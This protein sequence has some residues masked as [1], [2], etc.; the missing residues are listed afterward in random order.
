MPTTITAFYSF[1][2]NTK[3]KSS[4]VNTNFNNFRGNIIP[5]NDDTQTAS[6]NTHD[7]GSTEHR[8][9]NAYGV[10]YYYAGE[11][12]TTYSEGNSTGGINFIIDGATSGVF[13]KYSGV[14]NTVSRS[15]GISQVSLNVGLTSN[16]V[17]AVEVS[18][19]VMT[20]NTGGIPYLFEAFAY[21][22]DTVAS[23][24]FTSPAVQANFYW[25]RDGATF[26]T[27]QLINQTNS[28]LPVSS[29]NTIDL[30]STGTHTY[31]FFMA[32]TPTLGTLSIR[33]AH[34]IARPLY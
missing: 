32:V 13:A 1:T 23:I 4:E 15:G 6:D 20:I 25:T 3:A 10:K 11:T 31:R 18:A 2:A 21:S 5:I 28:R 34:I 17:G 24:L 8:W 33:Y 9:R 7:L 22:G 19:A 30:S 26:G 16:T 14:T 12:T 27:S 29:I